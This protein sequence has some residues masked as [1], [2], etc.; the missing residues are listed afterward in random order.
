MSIDKLHPLTVMLRVC[1]LIN[2]GI[3]SARN[4]TIGLK[5]MEQVQTPRVQLNQNLEILLN[6]GLISVK[7][8]EYFL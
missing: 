7:Y 8:L 4:L 2:N 1:I 3:S 6:F 5:M